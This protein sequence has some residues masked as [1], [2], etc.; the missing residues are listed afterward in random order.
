[1]AKGNIYDATDAFQQL[2]ILNDVSSTNLLKRRAR[3][4]F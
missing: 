2:L 3:F 4:K 1:M